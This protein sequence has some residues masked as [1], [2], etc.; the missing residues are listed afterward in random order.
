MNKPKQIILVLMILVLFGSQLGVFFVAQHKPTP[1]PVARTWTGEMLS[2]TPDNWS[3][4]VLEGFTSE[5]N[6]TDAP[7]PTVSGGGWKKGSIAPWGGFW[8]P[9]TTYL[10]VDI[11]TPNGLS[12]S[13]EFYYVLL[14]CIDS[15]GSYDQI[16]FSACYG[17]WGLTWSWTSVDWLGGYTYHYD[18]SAITLGSNTNYRFEMSLS[19]GYLTYNLVVGGWI[20]WTKRVYTGGSYFFL[21]CAVQVGIFTYDSFTNYEEVYYTDDQT[22]DFNFKFQ[23]TQTLA[24]YWDSWNVYDI[25]AP[26]GVGVTISTTDHYVYVTNPD[27]P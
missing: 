24:G 21:T 3:P 5:W 7:A 10:C 17:H 11:K 4:Y 20:E 27:A 13:G 14:S 8:P 19:N 22:P 12:G 25:R 6:S 16:G 9:T 2:T 15:A 26:A 23:S 18:A 1:P